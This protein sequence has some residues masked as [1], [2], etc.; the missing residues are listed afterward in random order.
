M[1]SINTRGAVSEYLA[2]AHLLK[3]GYKVFKNV[4][5]TGI[6]LLAYDG[7][8]FYRCEVKTVSKPVAGKKHII[9]L[10]LEQYASSD[11]ILGVDL[12]CNYVHLLPKTAFTIRN[13]VASYYPDVETCSQIAP[14]A[15]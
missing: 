15:L 4:E 14:E 6:D 10:P 7:K 9:Q 12:D 1:M 13:T 8:E 3:L 5:P 11:L 2:V